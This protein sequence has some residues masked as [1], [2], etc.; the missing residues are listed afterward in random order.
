MIP[1]VML[2]QGQADIDEDRTEK[3][4]LSSPP[5]IAARWI[6]ALPHATDYYYNH[7]GELLPR[8]N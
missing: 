7:A 3:L 2:M 6:L 8:R 5:G 4:I 1:S